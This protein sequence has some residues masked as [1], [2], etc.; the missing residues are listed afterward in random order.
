MFEK[1]AEEYAKNQDKY[2]VYSNYGLIVR[3]EI[4]A[5]FQCNQEL[6]AQIEKMQCCGNCG[7]E[8]CTSKYKG[9]AAYHRQKDGFA[10]ADNESW[11][12]RNKEE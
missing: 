8:K 4:S 1:E 2:A 7:N 6:K 11:V 3:L 9:N 10:C 12:M 5:G